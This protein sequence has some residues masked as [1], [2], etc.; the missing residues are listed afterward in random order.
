MSKLNLTL[1]YYPLALAAKELQ[2]EEIELLLLA[3]EGNITF[4]EYPDPTGGMLDWESL[5]AFDI[6]CMIS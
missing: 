2:K 5:S 6:G 3:Q 4:Y 1:P